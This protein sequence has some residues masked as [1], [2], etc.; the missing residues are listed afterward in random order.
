[1][2]IDVP[3]WTCGSKEVATALAHIDW[4]VSRVKEDLVQRFMVGA[5]QQILLCCGKVLDDNT[6]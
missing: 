1:M 4:T 5:D 3:I 2:S 6:V